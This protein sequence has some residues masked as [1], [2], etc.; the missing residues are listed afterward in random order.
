MMDELSKNNLW[1]IIEFAKS[2]YIVNKDIEAWL[3]IAK[4]I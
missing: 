4:K 2:S 3:C 1:K